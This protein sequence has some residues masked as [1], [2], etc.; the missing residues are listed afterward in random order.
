[1]IA[2][3]GLRRTDSI[4]LCQSVLFRRNLL[5]YGHTMRTEVTENCKGS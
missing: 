3:A 5:I 1:M 2:K 4:G